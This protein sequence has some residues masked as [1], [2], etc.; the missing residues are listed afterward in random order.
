MKSLQSH[1]REAL[2]HEERFMKL[3]FLSANESGL[4]YE[5]LIGFIDVD[6]VLKLCAYTLV[7]K[8]G[9]RWLEVNSGKKYL[10]DSNKPGFSK[11]YADDEI[12][13][14]WANHWDELSNEYDKMLVSSS[15]V[16][17]STIDDVLSMQNVEEIKAKV[18]SMYNLNID[19][20]HVLAGHT[21]DKSW[22]S[23]VETINKKVLHQPQ[24]V[25][26]TELLAV[27]A[28]ARY[29]VKHAKQMTIAESAVDWNQVKEWS[30]TYYMGSD[31]IH[32]EIIN[33][34]LKD[35]RFKALKHLKVNARYIKRP[36]EL[37]WAAFTDNAEHSIHPTTTLDI[38]DAR[39]QMNSKGQVVNTKNSF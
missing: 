37:V 1:I 19:T 5:Q 32:D 31:R 28:S 25:F 10:S 21:T 13:A 33:G 4:D 18:K 17:E 36:D 9:K 12:P 30:V 16:V 14:K 29:I 38:F 20:R 35:A 11:T 39:I 26:D 3:E 7:D 24:G 22:L 6:T 23:R 15:E 2:L 8:A 27:L 34:S